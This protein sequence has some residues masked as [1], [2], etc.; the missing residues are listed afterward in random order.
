MTRAA[1]RQIR[2]QASVL[3]LSKR[4]IRRWWRAMRLSSEVSA[5]A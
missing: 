1:P 2:L 4:S 3:A 5:D